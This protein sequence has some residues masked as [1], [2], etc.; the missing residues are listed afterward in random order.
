MRSVGLLFFSI[1][2][3]A[4]M[5]PIPEITPTAST[6]FLLKQTQLHYVLAGAAINVVPC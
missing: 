6:L 5:V 3:L 1:V 4:I 2:T